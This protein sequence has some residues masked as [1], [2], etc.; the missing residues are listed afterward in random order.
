MEECNR[1]LQYSIIL[2]R[3]FCRDLTG[4][5]LIESLRLLVLLKHLNR[6]ATQW[7]KVPHKWL[8]LLLL[9]WQVLDSNPD[10]KANHIWS[11][12]HHDSILKYCG[13]FTPCGGC[14]S[15]ARYRDCA[16]VDEAVFSPCRT[17]LCHVV[18]SHA[19]PR[20]A[21]PSIASPRPLL[22][23]TV[24]ASMTQE[25]GEVTWPPR[26]PQWRNNRRALV[27]R[28]LDQGFIS[29]TELVYE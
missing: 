28:L 14:G 8:A 2:E 27:F 19:S 29:E 20:P 1:K 24:N 7:R 12:R 6:T 9:T 17:E 13:L 25:W 10:R 15:E 18:P 3:S 21:L 11:W 16:T 5:T 22:G 4:S 26:V 23:D